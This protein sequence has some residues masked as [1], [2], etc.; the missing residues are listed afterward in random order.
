VPNE[1]PQEIEPHVLDVRRF[2]SIGVAICLNPSRV[3]AQ[4]E[5]PMSRLAPA[6]AFVVLLA[7]APLAAQ[8]LP[9]SV[10]GYAVMAWATDSGFPAEAD[11]VLAI[12]QGA[13]GYLWLGT[14]NGLFRFDGLQFVLWG[15]AGEQA[16]PGR[17]VRN[18]ITARDGSIWM[19]FDDA[20]GVS[21]ARGTTL[22]NYG[23]AEGLPGGGVRAVLEDRAGRIWAG[24]IA[25]LATFD[26]TALA[27]GGRRGGAARRRGAQ[28]VRGQR[29]HDLD[30]DERRRVSKR[31]RR[32]HHAVRPARDQH[33][34]L[35]GRRRQYPLDYGLGPG[36]AAAA[37]R[38]R[39]RLASRGAAPDERH[40]RRSTPN[41]NQELG[42]RNRERSTFV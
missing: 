22:T 18:L 4:T 9:D 42:A 38:P 2:G 15:A 10:E 33:P 34:E 19:T 30:R 5:R 11:A 35:R 25:G 40:A 12:T 37:G 28:P 24:S 39:A 21:R 27:A 26:R 16:L 31:R 36:G 14:R 8:D 20:D 32:A 3:L 41:T 29:R 17:S 6:A 13:D 1:I 7:A 23:V